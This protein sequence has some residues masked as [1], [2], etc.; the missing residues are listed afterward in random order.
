M[1]VVVV[2]MWLL[3]VALVS[4]NKFC[5]FDVLDARL[6]S[7]NELRARFEATEMP[8]LV[9]HS[10]DRWFANY[11]W[12]WK[13]IAQWFDGKKYLPTSSLFGERS[14]NARKNQLTMKRLVHDNDN[15]TM[16]FDEYSLSQ[17]TIL[18]Q[19]LRSHMR[20]RA[21]FD[22]TLWSA[23]PLQQRQTIIAPVRHLLLL[24]NYVVIAFN[25]RACL[26]RRLELVCN[27]VSQC[28]TNRI[29]SPSCTDAH[30]GLH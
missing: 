13:K 12:K 5:D 30:I 17:E 15:A 20:P 22:Q 26:W 27:G 23:V 7:D 28:S 24:Y 3:S 4:P 14:A 9:R 29:G 2:T 25:R 8:L 21:P 1:A 6:L 19:T 10:T 11:A 18:A 16:F